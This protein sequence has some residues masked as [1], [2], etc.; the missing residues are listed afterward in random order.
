MTQAPKIVRIDMLDTDYAKMI[1][2][3]LIPEE[4]RRRLE[5]TDPHTFRY[6]NKQISRYRHGDLDREG[7]DNVLC[8]IASTV[9][10]LTPADL[11]DIHDRLR[12]TG[13]LYLTDGERQQIL[14]WLT[15]EFA[16]TLPHPV[17]ENS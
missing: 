10:L 8:N 4:R 5:S 12:N 16:I 13:H 14:N 9:G 11:E 1:D 3:D 7:K 2:S 6:L 17:S 15:D